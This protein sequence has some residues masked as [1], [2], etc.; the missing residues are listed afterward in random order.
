MA[1]SASASNTVR[2][3]S[4][5]SRE[6]TVTRALTATAVVPLSGGVAYAQ[7]TQPPGG[8]APGAA[9]GGQRPPQ[10]E[11]DPRTM[12]GGDCRDNPYNCKD[13]PNPLPKNPSV[14]I[15]EMTWMDV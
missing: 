9:Q 11:R 14:F 15:E 1:N 3:Q 5:R 7:P 8:G 12:G 13:T 10:R 6:M 2:L 4:K